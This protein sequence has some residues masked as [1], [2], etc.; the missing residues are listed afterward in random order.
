MAFNGSGTFVRVY[1]WATDKIN[2]IKITASRMDTEMDGMATGLSTCMLKDGTQTLTANIPYGGYKNTG[3]AAGSARTDSSRVAEIQDST[4]TYA[5]SGGSA[6]AYTLTLAPAI[7]AYAAGQTFSF[8][9][10]HGTMIGVPTLNVSAVG[11]KNIYGTLGINTDDLIVVEYDGTQFQVISSRTARPGTN[12]LLNGEMKVAQRG[13]TFT[14]PTN[15]NYLLD[16]WQYATVGAGAITVTQST[17]VPNSTFTNSMKIDVTTADASL[18]ASDLYSI[19]QK[20]EGLR[21]SRLGFGGAGAQSITVS[22]WVKVVSG[23]LSFPLTLTGAISNSAGDRSYPFEVTLATASTWQKVSVT[24]PGDTTGTWLQTSGI[25][26]RMYLALALGSNYQG[27][28]AAWTATGSPQGTANQA[29]I[30]GNTANDIYITGVQLEV[31]SIATPFE[32]RSYGE[33]LALCQRYFWRMTRG[34]SDNQD[35]ATAFCNTTT[36][37]QAAMPNPVIMRASPTFAA[38]ALADVTVRIAGGSVVCTNIVAPAS[39]IQSNLMSATVASG[40]TAGQGCTLVING[41]AKWISMSAE[42]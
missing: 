9:A 11:A 7:T 24:I 14:S 32:Y 31:G 21:C 1:S 8:K 37:A 22:R 26:L 2:S 19:T 15:G 42:L 39:G 40:L 4:F 33:E 29:N 6:G 41:D 35:F 16:Q 17:D 34:T 3:M 12:L 20:I 10:N 13:A 5:A 23:A 28:A 18:A 27:T 36:V 38:S 30:M 25:G